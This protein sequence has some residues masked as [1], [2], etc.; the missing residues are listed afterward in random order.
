MEIN[1]QEFK[2][3]IRK[4]LFEAHRNRL[5]GIVLYGSMARGRITADSDI[6]LLVLLDG[7]ISYGADLERNIHAL[8]QVS[9][10]I[11]RRISP[12]PVAAGQYER[13]D[14]PLY[15]SAHQEGIAI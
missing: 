12:K 13:L 6:D 8:Y 10:Q 15:R 2:T 9:L 5:R 11:G 14:C 1:D 7:P 4:R 3:E